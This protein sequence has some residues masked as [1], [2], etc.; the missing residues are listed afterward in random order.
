MLV[1]L[2]SACSIVYP[3]QC[4]KYCRKNI[5]IIYTYNVC[6][7]TRG[8]SGKNVVNGRARMRAE[9]QPTINYVASTFH[10]FRARCGW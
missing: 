8:I 2:V 1:L 9:P 7:S 5:H 4:I 10:L 3:L 6:T